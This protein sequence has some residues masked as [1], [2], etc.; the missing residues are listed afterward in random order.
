MS[1]VLTKIR[2]LSFTKSI[3]RNG[4][5]IQRSTDR[6][7][8]KLTHRGLLIVYRVIQRY[9]VIHVPVQL[10]VLQLLLDHIML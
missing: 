5:D 3:Q 8:E 9:N 2:I 7:T 6:Y 1:F 10:K 4:N